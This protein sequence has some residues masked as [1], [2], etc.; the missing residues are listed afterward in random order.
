MC[1]YK[2]A[3]QCVN[4]KQTEISII[5]QKDHDILEEYNTDD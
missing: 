5:Y 4:S 3:T 2:K 1:N